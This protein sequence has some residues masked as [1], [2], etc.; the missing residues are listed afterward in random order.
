MNLTPSLPGGKPPLPARLTSYAR[1]HTQS[2]P[3]G[4]IFVAHTTSPLDDRGKSLKHFVLSHLIGG[5][6][7]AVVPLARSGAWRTH[8]V[9]I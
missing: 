7:L 1:V 2:P 6:S 9:Y 3:G 5:A 8:S 4:V